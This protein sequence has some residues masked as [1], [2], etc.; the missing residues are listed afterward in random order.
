MRQAGKDRSGGERRRIHR[1]DAHPQAPGQAGDELVIYHRQLARCLH[2]EL[3]D[4][5]KAGGR[6]GDP[7]P[8]RACTPGGGARQA[9]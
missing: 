4:E 5:G 6:C 3:A 9:R 1:Q 8:G 7:L 2:F